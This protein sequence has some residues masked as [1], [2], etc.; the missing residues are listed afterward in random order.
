MDPCFCFFANDTFI[1]PGAA[2]FMRSGIEVKIKTTAQGVAGIIDVKKF[3]VWIPGFNIF[4]RLNVQIIKFIDNSKQS[5]Q[6]LLY[7]KIR[8]KFFLRQIKFLLSQLF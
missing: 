4:A 8:A 6:H 3:D 5:F 1:H 2:T 7:R